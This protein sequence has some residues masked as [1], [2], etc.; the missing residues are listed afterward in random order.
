VE[1]FEAIDK[2]LSVDQ[3]WLIRKS[4]SEEGFPR[5]HQDLTK[6][7]GEKSIVK[8]IVVNI[9]EMM[10]HG[11]KTPLSTNI[12]AKNS[13]PEVQSSPEV[14]VVNCDKGE[15]DKMNRDSELLPVDEAWAY[16]EKHGDKMKDMKSMCCR[17]Y[18][19]QCSPGGLFGTTVAAESLVHRY[20]KS[21]VWY[22]QGFV[23]GFIALVQ[24]DAHMT[25]PPY[26]DAEKNI[27]LRF[28]ST[29]SQIIDEDY[30]KDLGPG[31]THIVT[32]AYTPGH[33]ALLYFDLQEAT[34]TVLDGLR[35]D[36]RKWE[37]H[38]IYTL[39]VCCLKPLDARPSS[40]TTTTTVKRDNRDI[41]T[42]VM[43]ISFKSD[44][45][46]DRAWPEWTVTN[47]PS[48]RQVD[49]FNCG[50]IACVKVMEVFGILEPGSLSVIEEYG[51]YRTVV[52]NYYQECISK[53][54]NEIFLE[55]RKFKLD[56]ATLKES[57][58]A[59]G[60][61][62][63]DENYTSVARSLAMQ[64]RN[65]QQA[66]SAEKE[67]RRLG[68]AALRNGATPGAVVT[69]KVD[70][71]THS[72]AQG[73]IGI[74]FDVKPTGGIKVCCEH[75]II[76]HSG[77]PGVY[78]V[79]AD[80]YVVRAQADDFFPLTEELYTVRDLV[81]DGKF[82]EA[83]TPTISYNKLHDIM[84]GATS[85]AKKAPG[86]KCKNGKCGKQCGCRRKGARCH[87]GCSCTGNCCK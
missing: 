87:S 62:E 82:N 86:C 18:C 29:P 21:Q 66:A 24:H 63:E 50:P 60:R 52:M 39:K 17:I 25:P 74:V 76:T 48:I 73:L 2:T 15:G 7:E 51:S 31:V 70:Y 37:R 72:H 84:I 46:P 6:L 54:N 45:D 11:E 26:K 49:G 56:R 33:F 44:S 1:Y 67:I 27:V 30:C 40:L 77:G 10:M 61:D 53:Y 36:I 43:N 65:N 23:E 75:G 83:T 34:V 12:E 58:E 64:K 85:P 19:D 55:V 38:I 4:E 13:S 78:W 41:V 68:V 9:G 80:K 71:R 16:L 42:R 81:L 14:E 8:T 32:P 22:D 35:V 59:Q 20:T 57:A 5:W 69:L 28:A 47:D 79:P 3:V